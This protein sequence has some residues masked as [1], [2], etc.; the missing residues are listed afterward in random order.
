M[1]DDRPPLEMDE[2]G[3]VLAPN[4]GFQTPA[5]VSDKKDPDRIVV[6]SAFPSSNQ[7]ILDVSSHPIV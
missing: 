4:P 3:R 5:S 1:E 6:Y 2:K 7:A